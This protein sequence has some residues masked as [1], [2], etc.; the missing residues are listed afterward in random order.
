MCPGCR[1]RTSWP[2]R[3]RPLYCAECGSPTCDDCL[4]WYERLHPNHICKRCDERGYMT[5]TRCTKDYEWRQTG[6]FASDE[7]WPPPGSGIPGSSSSLPLPPQSISSAFTGSTNMTWESCL[8]PPQELQVCDLC[9]H[10]TCPK[11]MIHYRV[12]HNRLIRHTC[13]TCY[14]WESRGSST[15]T[16]SST[17]PAVMETD[18]PGDEPEPNNGQAYLTID[19]GAS[20]SVPG[21]WQNATTAVATERY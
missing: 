20:P 9:D 12:R 2:A 17:P 13:T 11:H 6:G 10:N 18:E 5:C 3:R 15:S 14:L 21:I 7:P 16:G 1:N 8:R 19:A 4:V